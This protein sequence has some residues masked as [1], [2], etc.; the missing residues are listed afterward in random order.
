MKNPVLF[1]LILFV[2]NAGFAQDAK[3]SSLQVKTETGPAVA[4]RQASDTSVA[5]EGIVVRGFESNARLLNVPASISLISR[6]DLI[7]VSSFSLLPAF[8]NLAGVRM[9]ERSPSSYRLSIRGS[10]LRSPFGVR[11]VKVYLDDFLLTDAGGNTYMNLLDVTSIGGAELIKGPAGSLYGAGTGGAVLLSSSSLLNEK[12]QDTG[13]L[14]LRLSGGRFGSFQEAVQY[15]S[16]GKGYSISVLQGH[17]Q[18]DGYRDNSRS[19]KDNL[20]FGM[21]IRASENVSTDVFVLLSDLYYQTPGGLNQAQ[22]LANPRQSRPATPALPSAKEQRAAIYNKTA[23]LGFSNTYH[24]SSRW[25]TVTS[26]T[27]G[28]T[29]FKNPFITNYEKRRETNVGLRSKIVYEKKG[30]IPLQWTSGVEVQKGDYRIDSSGNNKGISDGKMVRDQVVAR[31]QFLFTQV[32]M[33]PLPFLHL[34]SGFSFNGFNYSIDRTVGQPANGKQQLNF[35]GQLLP[36]VAVSIEPIGGL[37]L[38]AQLSRGY[39]SP[40]IAEVRPSAGGIFSDLQ[41]EQGWNREAGINIASTENRFFARAVLFRFDLKDAI[42]RQTNAAGAEYFVNAGSTIQKGIEAEFS[43]VAFNRPMAK[44]IQ[45]LR[46]STAVT[47]NRFVFGTYVIGNANFSGNKLTGVPDEVFTAS[48]QVDFLKQCYAHIN[49]NYTGTIPLNDANTV[50]A[51]P[52]RLWQSKLGWKTTLVGKRTDLFV[53][54]DNVGDAVYSLGNDINAFGSR[55]FNPAATRNLQV[56]LS[57]NLL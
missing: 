14:Q 47:F 13:A 1:L 10:L 50:L 55:F 49:L 23:L 46:V 33:R 52:Y 54:M 7:R 41:A 2:A 12:L 6:E 42:V 43:W 21:K 30:S 8:N 11:N 3:D 36:R 56:G 45:F 18:A 25:K 32:N 39:A 24:L 15:Q 37:A 20:Q 34:Q 4:D 5:L 38:Y 17:A 16:N 53:L 44:G 31:Q 35:N 9:E 28:L 57:I 48:L 51:K 27:T 26:F 22:A 29:G 19:R 40:S